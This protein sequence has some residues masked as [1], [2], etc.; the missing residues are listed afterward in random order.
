MRYNAMQSKHAKIMQAKISILIFY[1]YL[2]L[3]TIFLKRL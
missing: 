1:I 2:E 3:L